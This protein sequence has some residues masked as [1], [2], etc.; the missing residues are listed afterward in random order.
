MFL[1]RHAPA[2]RHG[3][4]NTSTNT[5]I[6]SILYRPFQARMLKNFFISMLG[7]IAGFWISLMLFMVSCMILLAGSLATSLVNSEVNSA[8]IKDN[9]ILRISF[10]ANIEERGG[11]LSFEKVLQDA[12]APMTL[13]NILRAIS[14]AKEDKHIAG[15]YLDCKGGSGGIATMQAIQKALADFQKSGKWVCAYSDN[16]T[17]GNYYIASGAKY[18]YLNPVG[19]VDVRG[20]GSQIP[21]FKNLLDKLGVKM[22]IFKVGTYK[23]AV[24]PFILTEMSPASRE[25]TDYFLK[26]IWNNMSTT[27]AQN[28]KVSVATVNQWADSLS[29]FN[30]PE[31]YVKAK[32]VDKLL[33][34]NELT[35]HLKKITKTKKDDD[36][37]FI[38]YNV[39]LASAKVPHEKSNKNKIAVLYACGDIVDTGDEGI[40]AEKMVPEILDLAEDDDI[41]AM[42]LRV[43]SGGGSAFASEQI[44]HALEV[45]KQNGKTLYVSMGDYAASGGYYISCG[46]DRIFAEPSTLTGSIGIFGMIPDI[47]GLLNDK[48]GIN[49]STVTTNANGDFPTITKA[50]TPYQTAKMQETIA[51]GYDLFTKRCAQGRNIPQDSIK[52]IGEGRVWDGV[53]AK[54]IGL[55]DNLGGLQTAIRSLAKK[56]KYDNYQV[57]TYPNVEKNFWDM[58]AEM[59]MQAKTAAMKDELGTF[60]PVYLEM[61]R[62]EG[63]NPIQARMLPVTMQ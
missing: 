17:Q 24:E 20:L 11:S 63:F 16:Y 39:Y 15:I 44:W 19:S 42:V 40:S 8:E 49:L 21:F 1:C 23:S 7:A 45:F 34:A 61:K 6:F 30:A 4:C 29:V 50:V 12:P 46:A 41:K 53:T 9:S 27:I 28:R 22:Q 33:Y 5:F 48:I 55:V 62:L 37:N 38:D 32:M 54:R 25:M 31:T 3:V 56:M 43:N 60:Y 58:L 14:A 2:Q 26:N 36:L 52:A 47:Q 13:E 35:D 51:R 10:D 18:L 57:V 59:P